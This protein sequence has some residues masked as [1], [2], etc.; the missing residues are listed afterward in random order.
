VHTVLGDFVEAAGGR[1]DLVAIKMVE[2]DA[3]FADR[4]AFLDG[5]RHIG[6]SERGSLE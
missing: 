5:F 2:W 3:T 1:L 4:I 6:F